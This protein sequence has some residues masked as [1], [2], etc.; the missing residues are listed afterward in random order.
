MSV[1]IRASAHSRLCV[2]AGLCIAA[3]LPCTAAA[4][5]F[6][7]SQDPGAERQAAEAAARQSRVAENLSTPCKQAIKDKKIAVIIGEEQTNGV[8]L[9]RQDNYGPHFQ[10]INGRL[11]ALGL[12]TYTPEEIRRQIAQAEIDAYFKNDPDA[13]LSA[14][15]RLGANFVLRGLITSQASYNPIVRVNQVSVGMGFTLA[16]SNGR[17][18]ANAAANAASYAGP[19][20][21]AMAVTLLNENADEVVSQ[22]YSEYCRNAE[23]AAPARAKK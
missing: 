19:D 12:R 5:G 8:I 14:S 20:V 1:K 23:V 9:A 7:F 11:Q 4:Q 3:L 21:R 13:A 16:A 18:V 10:I 6:K 22:L 15:R 2:C 17:T